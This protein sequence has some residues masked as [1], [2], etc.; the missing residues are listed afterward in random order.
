MPL[1][2]YDQMDRLTPCAACG[3]RRYW[4]DGTAWQCWACVPPPSPGMIY[5]DLK[6]RVN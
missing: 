4:F 5:L 2:T 3:S 6:E 1:L